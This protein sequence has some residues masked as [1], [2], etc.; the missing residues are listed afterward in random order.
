MIVFSRPPPGVRIHTPGTPQDGHRAAHHEVVAPALVA[1]GIRILDYG[2]GRFGAADAYHWTGYWRSG[3]EAVTALRRL[4]ELNAPRIAVWRRLRLAKQARAAAEA[5]AGPLAGD[6]AEQ[7][8]RAALSILAP[9][10]GPTPAHVTPEIPVK[11]TKG[12]KAVG[13]T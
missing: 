2:A 9:V 12:S 7:I 13:A 5:A 3:E 8:T 6:L 10:R 11:A 4:Q 1:D